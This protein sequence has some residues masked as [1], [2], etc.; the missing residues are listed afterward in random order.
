M[1]KTI[2]DTHF[3]MTYNMQLLAKSA[4]KE[5]VSQNLSTD[6]DQQAYTKLARSINPIHKNPISEF[7]LRMKENDSF[8]HFQYMS[9]LKQGKGNLPE[10]LTINDVTVDG[11]DIDSV[12]PEQLKKPWAHVSSAV[13]L[14]KADRFG[15]LTISSANTF[16]SI[17]TRCALTLSYKK[18]EV[19]WLSTGSAAFL[20][21]IYYR[22]M[23]SIVSRSFGLDVIEETIVKF[24]FAYYMASMLTT[25]RDE[26]G[27]PM[28]MYRIRN[29][30]LRGNTSFED[31]LKQFGD[32]LSGEEVN[33]FYVCSFIA[34]YGP[35]RIKGF[36]AQTIYRALMDSSRNS[37]AALVAADYPPYLLYLVMRVLSSDKHPVL[38]NVLTKQMNRS[39]VTSEI[40][41]LINTK[42][43]FTFD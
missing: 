20:I 19:S 6:V 10:L 3:G 34:K 36:N 17:S 37:I 4:V 5:L 30:F 42:A 27:H 40:R 38:T 11:N 31:L 32:H 18:A 16:M 15:D 25:Q 28:L 39:I 35:E 43:L 8:S 23:G 9:L 24:A 12:V 22:M 41:N 29:T 21:D 33:M 1:N 2:F 7:F 26:D 14:P 13:T